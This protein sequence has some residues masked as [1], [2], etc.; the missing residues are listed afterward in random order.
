MAEVATVFA[1]RV[2]DCLCVLCRHAVTGRVHIGDVLVNDA[3]GFVH[4]GAFLAIRMAIN[5]SSEGLLNI[6]HQAW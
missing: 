3:Q 1:T 6:R 5:G 2:I 4:D